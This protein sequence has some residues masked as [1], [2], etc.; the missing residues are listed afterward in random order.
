MAPRSF[1]SDRPRLARA[2][3]YG[4][5]VLLVVAI[6]AIREIERSI[7]LDLGLEWASVD[8]E[9]YESI[10]L[11]QEFLRFDTS[12]PDGNEIPAAEWLAGVLEAEG[13][14]VHLERL[15]ERNANLW[16]TIPGEDPRA[17]V[18]HNHIDVLPIE[19]PEAWIVPPFSGALAPPFVYGRGAFD[20][21][22]LGIAQLV[23]VLE[24]KRS[25]EPLKRSLTFLAT[26][27][28]ERDS[29]LGTRRLLQE[30]PEWAE[31]FWAVLTEG[32]AVETT[33]IDTVRYW[34]TE[35]LQKRFVDIWVCDSDRR[36]LEEL[37]E[38]LHRRQL[39]W[40]S[41]EGFEAFL[42]HYVPSRDRPETRAA[43][44]SPTEVLERLRAW[45]TDIGP[46]VVPPYIDFM[47]R[48]AMIVAFPIEQDP[49]GGFLMRVILHLQPDVTVEEVWD[50]LIGDDLEGYTYR[51]ESTHPPLDP[52][53]SPLDH[54][55]FR[56]LDELMDERYPAIDHGPLYV[57]HTATD[58]RYFRQP[59]FE[60]P[61]YGFSPFVILAVDAQK[62]KGA[63]ERMA[64]L[65]FIEGVETYVS[66]V[67]RLVLE[68]PPPVEPVEDIG[69]GSRR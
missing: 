63:N 65:P 1:F 14:D 7:E 49:S 25:G 42:P 4:V 30:H 69:G 54:E 55:A 8:Y 16:A 22:S 57:P 10:R 13:I 31:Q 24:V 33:D 15:G 11:F 59:G 61:T 43:F 2:L 67:E 17:L 44:A 32:G 28:E 53:G 64:A 45:P 21:K 36:R 27:D 60:I 6:F 26:G 37:R 58:A 23:A 48:E 18:L 62:L 47:L 46:T 29:W 41:I 39:G 38:I 35:F 40:R 5:P 68:N 50:E 19:R 20:M 3:L 51:V 56:I 52:A 9:K 34:G 66:L 12:Y